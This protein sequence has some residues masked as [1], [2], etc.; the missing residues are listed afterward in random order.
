MARYLAKRVAALIGILAVIL[1]LNNTFEN[2]VR[3]TFVLEMVGPKDL[4]NAVTLNSVLV[5]VARAVG[6][7]AAVA[8]CAYMHACMLS[9]PHT[10]C[11][12]AARLETDM[13]LSNSEHESHAWR[14][15]EVAP[16]YDPSGSTSFLAAQVI[17][18]LLGYVFHERA[19]RSAA[20]LPAR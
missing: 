5:N 13:R 4:R 17:L 14:I 8:E 6:P 19:K 2:P 16:D 3:Q 18:N 10:A 7:A 9:C 15:C 12:G 20:A 11:C 1:G